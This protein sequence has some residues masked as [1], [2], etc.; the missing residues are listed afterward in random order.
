MRK[1]DE[2]SLK[3]KVRKLPRKPGVYLM[4]D[5]FGTILYVGKAKNLKNRVSSYFQKGRRSLLSPK[6]KILVELIHDFEIHV[7]RSETEALLLEGRLIKELKPKYYTEFTDAKQIIQIR[8][9]LL[10]E[11]PIFRIVRVRT[12]DKARYFGPFPHSTEVRKTLFL[13]RKKFGILLG[14]AHP[15]KLK[16]GNWRLYNDA[17]AEIYESENEISAEE[18]RSR[19][20][21]A[22]EFL[23][24]RDRAEIEKLSSEMKKAAANLEYEKAG[25]L[26]DRIA[27]IKATIEK[28]RRF[29]RGNPLPD[30][31]SPQKAL[32]ALGNALQMPFPPK[33]MECFD[34]SHISGTFV[35]ASCVHFKNGVPEKKEYRH[36]KIKKFLGNDDFRSMNE[37][38]ERRYGRLVREKKPFPDIVVIDG[39]IGQV[40]AALD[41]F[42][43]LGKAPAL[44]IG[45][46]KKEEL[47]IFHDGRK[48]LKLPENSPELHL[49]QRLRDEAHRFANSF[50]AKLRSKKIRE[51][52]LDDVPGLGEKRKQI[53][54][55]KF[56]TLSKI[57]ALSL[58]EIQQISGFGNALAKTLFDFLQKN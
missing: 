9:D 51:S 43:E 1:K 50:N 56:K 38:I 49:L 55:T 12:S 48:P 39:G 18:Y 41:V 36:F 24:G 58:E 52:I 35:V 57:K 28:S 5:R 15:Q 34:I 33:T 53:L 4:K 45:L 29:I 8:V 2:E 11:M 20:D 16:N 46:A 19:V 40:H 13:L 44:L 7:V 54:I 23:E 26:R 6:I 37:T 17:R 31:T 14:D 22:C 27:A 42:H 32:R 25:K 30:S 3:E 21:A 47:V 10:S